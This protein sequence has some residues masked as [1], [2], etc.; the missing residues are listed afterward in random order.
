[1]TR[2]WGAARS[3]L[4]LAVL[5][6][7]ACTRTYEFDPPNGGGGGVNGSDAGPFGGG[8]GVTDGGGGNSD[9]SHLHCGGNTS[10]SS[11]NAVQDKPA[12]FFAL[13]R[14]RTML[15]GLGGNNGTRFSV[16]RDAINAVLS[17]SS[18]YASLVPFGYYEFPTGDS[19]CNNNVCCAAGFPSRTGQSLPIAQA[20]GQCSMSSQSL[21][22]NTN[23][24]SAPTGQALQ[25]IANSWKQNSPG[26]LYTF[27][28]TDGKPSDDCA[29]DSSPSAGSAC[30]QTTNLINNMNDGSTFSPPVTPI[31]TI[32]IAIGAVELDAPPPPSTATYNSCL[33]KMAFAGGHPAL[34]S[35]TA[36]TLATTEAALR[37]QIDT[38]VTNAVCTFDID[39][40]IDPRS[41]FEVDYNGSQVGADP[42]NGFTLDKTKLTL[43][44][45]WCSTLMTAMKN[46][47][48]HNVTVKS[49]VDPS[50]P[51]QPQPNP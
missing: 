34:N 10:V 46:N 2:W 5:L 45:S 38:I 44:G 15:T 20:L 29:F 23:S 8:N 16:S 9:G 30:E 39:S 13:D 22:C 3:A 43:T 24:D 48:R 4:L 32:V 37:T 19:S 14:S 25:K 50:H 31:T 36:Y 35:P 1:M 6:P 26:P 40:A 47:T 41:P 7:A 27:L 11:F 21:T 51:F 42:L 28:I 49:C 12:F 17:S 18:P 33:N